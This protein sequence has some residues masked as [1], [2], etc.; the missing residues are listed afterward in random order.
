MAGLLAALASYSAHA[1]IIAT[2]DGSGNTRPPPDDPG[3]ANVG[4]IQQLTGIFLGNH[5]VLTARHV[6]V[7]AI[8]LPCGTFEPVQGRLPHFIK[9]TSKQSA[10]LL[11]FQIRGEP[12]LPSL[13]LASNPPRIYQ[14]V[15]MIGHG[16]S[17]QAQRLAWH[18]DWRRAQPRE[19]PAY[20]GFQGASNRTMRWGTN[21]IAVTDVRVGAG[22]LGSLAFATTF[23]AGNPTPFEAQAAAGDSGGGV[24]AKNLK[25][26]WELIGIMT[27]IWQFPNQPSSLSIYGNKTMIVSLFAYRDQI[28]KIINSTP[29]FDNDGIL[30]IDD[31]CGRIANPEQSDRDGN[32]VGDACEEPSPNL[33]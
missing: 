16:I 30:D 21:R 17:R 14:P 5:W 29:D 6:G 10:D 27:N 18:A 9:T 2:G 15:V 1:V 28:Q 25:A 3:W 8:E 23:D 20:E 22:S 19:H 11:L 24:F 32:A 31:N 12:K 13:K 7:H 4:R 26:E 33:H